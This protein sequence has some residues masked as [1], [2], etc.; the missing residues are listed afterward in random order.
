MSQIKLISIV[1]I[2]LLGLSG[3]VS[4]M[5]SGGDDTV[6]A[7]GQTM[8]MG[9]TFS[10]KLALPAANK[11]PIKVSNWINL[12]KEF[13]EILKDYVYDRGDYLSV[14]ITPQFNMGSGVK[15]GFGQGM[16]YL[17]GTSEKTYA[18]VMPDW[19]EKSA[20][21]LEL[22]ANGSCAYF[23]KK[24]IGNT[25]IDTSYITTSMA[26]ADHNAVADLVSKLEANSDKIKKYYKEYLKTKD[27]F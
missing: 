26:I 2:T 22:T 25:S 11:Y 6:R 9:D 4:T 27:S 14:Q 3:C 5:V 1:F 16:I 13:R 17:Q 19:R 24:E 12:P 7:K 18:L 15:S 10:S 23:Q 20:I 21:L 8:P